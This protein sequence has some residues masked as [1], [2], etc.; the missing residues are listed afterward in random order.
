MAD[1]EETKVK[2]QLTAFLD[3][4]SDCWHVPFHNTGFT[5]KGIPDRLVCY[6]GRFIAIEVKAPGATASKW[7]ERE[8]LAIRKAGGLAFT[9]TSVARL[10]ELFARLDTDIN[11]GMD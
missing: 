11:Y 9:L 2:K 3:K 6:R 5:R 10:P 1:T 8:I 7:Q 4:L